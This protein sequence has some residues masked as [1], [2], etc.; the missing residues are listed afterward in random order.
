MANIPS[1]KVQSR[2]VVPFVDME[3]R[4]KQ[5]KQAP[6]YS[7]QILESVYS[8]YSNNKTDIGYGDMDRIVNLRSIGRGT[9]SA[10]IYKRYF[11][12]GSGDSISAEIDAYFTGSAD[13]NRYGWMSV[14]WDN[15]SPIANVKTIAKSIIGGIDYDVKSS[16][17]DIHAID[18]EDRRMIR[19]YVLAK[20][21]ENLDNLR[22]KWGLHPSQE[23]PISDEYSD[24]LQIKKEG[25]FKAHYIMAQEQLLK[26][27]EQYSDWGDYVK[28]RVFDDLFDIGYAFAC[29]KYDRVTN[30]PKWE[31]IDAVDVVVQTTKKSDYS[32]IDYG[33]YFD[34]PT[35]NELR[36][37]DPLY[38]GNKYLS[39]REEWEQVAKSYVEYMGNINDS[40]FSRITGGEYNFSSEVGS[41]RVCRLNLYWKDYEATKDVEF[42]NPHGHKK[43]RPYKDGERVSERDRYIE[44]RVEKIYYG[45]LIIGTD[46]MQ[47]WG[48]M[49][50]MPRKNK[51]EALFPLVGI[52]L[53]EKSFTARL[54]PLALMFG[55]AWV[56]LCNAISKAQNDG[57]MID[58]AALADIEDGGKK[59]EWSDLVQMW[60]ED[61]IFL[62]D[63]TTQGP[64]IGGNG[65]P[66][67]KVQGTLLADMTKEL[68]LMNQMY[69]KIEQ[70]IGIP[71]VALG[72]SPTDRQAV[73]TTQMSVSSSNTAL[74][75]L[76]RA[77]MKVKKG[78]AQA[79]CS[80]WQNAIKY[81]D[82]C[83]AEAAKVIGQDDIEGIMAARD[84]YMEMGI[85]LEP[86]PSD[87]LI[88]IFTNLIM[89]EISRK[90]QGQP[91]IDAVDG[92]WLINN[93]KNGGN[94]YEAM[95]RV[96][97]LKKKDEERLLKEREMAIRQQGEA[98]DQNARTAAEEQRKTDQ[99]KVQASELKAQAD[100]R[101]NN[102][103]VQ[104]ELQ[105]EL[106]K[107]QRKYELEKK[108]ASQAL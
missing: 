8:Y 41:M 44:S 52:K 31:Y 59:L 27:T 49:E 102:A 67:Q 60:R 78:L 16:V 39:T 20:Y 33:G 103:K 6:E 84:E 10:D 7:R 70:L 80:M 11:S 21:K 105:S 87:E 51:R 13:A 79:S 83:R 36:G 40:E 93:L 28:E 94:F 45:S 4:S 75:Y 76:V 63:S 48:P 15:L 74:N 57:Y 34:Y 85:E 89:Q 50:N 22:G 12:P 53:F 26:W 69:S 43:R 77:T 2:E 61:S 30:K 17:V 56:R 55:I 106:V 24:L 62:W 32:D 96:K 18:E 23:Q 73:R 65:A 37:G 29:C 98:I 14:I 100:M 1:E 72:V 64:G 104:D 66:L 42:V 35:I 71:P 91:G 99:M 46:W 19:Q 25:G 54:A 58:I 95:C 86:R 81:S 90:N 5:E 92:T 47:A 101:V 88:E 3:F 108:I 68:E 82:R 97:Y 38:D 9:Q 107:M